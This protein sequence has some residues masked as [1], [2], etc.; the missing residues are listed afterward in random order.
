MLMPEQRPRKM[1][2]PVYGHTA[3]CHKGIY[4]ISSPTV[5]L[6]PLYPRHTT[7]E[8]AL[9]KQLSSPSAPSVDHSL[10]GALTYQLHS[11][12]T[13]LVSSS[14]DFS[15]LYSWQEA[16]QMCCSKMGTPTSSL[17]V[18]VTPPRWD[19]GCT[20][21]DE[22]NSHHDENGLEDRVWGGRT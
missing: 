11:G 18:P 10:M 3:S 1:E 13:S 20:H 7:K 22:S 12:G 16:H 6:R 17:H 14:R 9:A 21:L 4:Q 5:R 8:T 15:D 2:P 19:S